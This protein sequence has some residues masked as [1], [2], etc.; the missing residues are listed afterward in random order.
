MDFV[1]MKFWSSRPP[2]YLISAVDGEGLLRRDATVHSLIHSLSHSQLSLSTHEPIWH[3]ERKR[4]SLFNPH[5]SWGADSIWR[6]SEPCSVHLLL[7]PA[8][9]YLPF[10]STLWLQLLFFYSF[11][12]KSQK[13]KGDCLPG[14]MD[15][16]AD[17]WADGWTQSDRPATWYYSSTRESRICASFDCQ[18]R[19]GKANGRRKTGGHV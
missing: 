12:F 10:S 19:E 2:C 11:L 6:V 13:E 5:Y 8:A 1:N 3:W 16:W 4:F 9:T 18:G 15:G 17:G 7:P 14:W